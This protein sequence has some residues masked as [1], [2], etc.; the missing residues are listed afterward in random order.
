MCVSLLKGLCRPRR[1]HALMRSTLKSLAQ[2]FEIR[3][4]SSGIA[5]IFGKLA[6]FCIYKC[7]LVI[8]EAVCFDTF[9][10][11]CNG[12]KAKIPRRV[13]CKLVSNGLCACAPAD[14]VPFKL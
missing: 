5:F 4:E 9:E 8:I 3:S 7:S 6:E 13:V 12:G 14:V 2:L 11:L 10:S 1:L